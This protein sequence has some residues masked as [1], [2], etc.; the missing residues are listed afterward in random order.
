MVVRHDDGAAQ[1]LHACRA[2]FVDAMRARLCYDAR[3]HSFFF[4]ENKAWRD[5]GR[6]Q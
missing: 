1:L 2:L 3:P 4:G 6:D 5:S